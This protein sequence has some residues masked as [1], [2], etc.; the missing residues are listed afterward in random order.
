MKVSEKQ[1]TSGLRIEEQIEM[2]LANKQAEAISGIGN[3]SASVTRLK[4][5]FLIFFYCRGIRCKGCGWEPWEMKQ[6]R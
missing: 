1:F 6:D 2:Y 4:K 5:Y 3:P